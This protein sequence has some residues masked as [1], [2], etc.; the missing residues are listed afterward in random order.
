MAG[1]RTARRIAPDRG[2]RARA[3]ARR[4]RLVAAIAY[5]D[6][7]VDDARLVLRLIFDAVGHGARALNHV[8]A[9]LVESGGRVAGARLVDR[10][11]GT[12][13]ECARR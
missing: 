12:R 5:R 6:G 3:R 11:D 13:A 9:T 10:I 8:E 7:V 1:Q 4:R 2:T